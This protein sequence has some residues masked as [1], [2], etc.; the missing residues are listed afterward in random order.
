[1]LYLSL[2]L[3]TEVLKCMSALSNDCRLMAK[4]FWETN[5]VCK[6]ISWYGGNLGP[7]V[8][9]SGHLESIG[10]VILETMSRVLLSSRPHIYTRAVTYFY[11]N[12]TSLG[13]G[14]L[15]PC[16][17]LAWCFP[18][19]FKRQEPKEWSSGDVDPIDWVNISLLTR[20]RLFPAMFPTAGPEDC[21]AIYQSTTEN[22]HQIPWE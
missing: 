13:H 14:Y 19:P 22:F 16:L 20:H 7:E 5:G 18:T 11:Y 8:N 4:V 17:F 6:D 15:D 3:A 21:L 9:T 1:M 2:I 10:Q 12:S